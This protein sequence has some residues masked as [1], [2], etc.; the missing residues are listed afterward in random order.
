MSFFW[1]MKLERDRKKTQQ[2]ILEQGERISEI[3]E[4][5]R[6][7]KWFLKFNF[8]GYNLNIFSWFSIFNLE[9][10]QIFIKILLLNFNF[11][12]ILEKGNIFDA[13]IAIMLCL[14]ITVPQSMGF[15]GGFILTAFLKKENENINVDANTCAPQTIN[16]TKSYAKGPSSI[17]VPG[18]LKGLLEIHENQGKLPWNELVDPSIELCKNG[19]LLTLH[20]HDSLYTNKGVPKD[21]YLRELFMENGDFKRPGAII[22]MAK[23]CEFLENIRDYSKDLYEKTASFIALD[24]K[25]LG[26]SINVEDFLKYQW[27]IFLNF[28]KD[29]R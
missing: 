3:I 6:M 25:D 19:T 29:F 20:L 4:K 2:T 11:R 10:H 17:A 8:F 1:R 23:H 22:H 14:S 28:Q 5:Y 24:L 16:L 7:A 27:V 9:F 12:A 13:T 26:S 21:Y 15:G 18:F